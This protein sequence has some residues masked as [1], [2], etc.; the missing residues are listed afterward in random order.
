MQLASSKLR[1][2][3]IGWA[4]C[5]GTH[6]TWHL[7]GSTWVVWLSVFYWTKTKIRSKIIGS[8]QL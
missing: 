6:P 2:A 7:A 5:S 4:L 1:R 8:D 3:I